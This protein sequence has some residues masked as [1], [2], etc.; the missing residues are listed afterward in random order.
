MAATN[1]P[2]PDGRAEQA[3]QAIHTATDGIARVLAAVLIGIARIAAPFVAAGVIAALAL[4]A[5]RNIEHLGGVV[6]KAA[7]EV[8]ALGALVTIGATLLLAAFIAFFH[9]SH[10]ARGI[11]LVFLVA[12]LILT[13]FL[14]LTDSAF[15]S[16]VAAVPPEIV[17]AG[18]FIFAALAGL[19]LLPATLV[20]VVAMRAPADKFANTYQ[21]SMAMVGVGVKFASIA[22]GISAELFFG[23]HYGISPLYTVVASVVIG[24]GF[25]WA[26]GKVDEA[27]TRRDMFDVWM[28]GFVSCIFA[29]YLIG[30]AAE[31]VQTLAGWQLF[32]ADFD[33]FAKTAYSLSLGVFTALF[34]ITYL[35]TS[36]IDHIQP[37]TSN[38]TPANATITKPATARLAGH[39]TRQR[40]GLQELTAAVR[41]RAALPAPAP[42][43][44]SF[45]NTVTAASAPGLNQTEPDETEPDQTEPDETEP[46]ETEPDETEPDETEPDVKTIPKKA[47]LDPNTLAGAFFTALKTAEQRTPEEKEAYQKANERMREIL[48]SYN[49]ASKKAAAEVAGGPSKSEGEQ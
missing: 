27:K 12:W 3:A 10:A 31:S 1:S 42:A 17:N 37:N 35:L 49:T 28:W 6:F 34:V 8:A 47:R 30:I 5:F 19:S 41:G 2:Q 32:G 45:A 7:P 9:A 18:T 13:V 22:A 16:G 14:V 43:S 48:S 33:T 24:F 4:F 26:L 25:L 39:I 36:N 20:P 23:L 46:D 15:T 38:A 21:A 11:A 44:Q 29:L 40:E